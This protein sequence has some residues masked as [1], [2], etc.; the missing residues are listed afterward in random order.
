MTMS[1]AVRS[2]H[3]VAIMVMVMVATIVAM[4]AIP[5]IRL[6]ITIDVFVQKSLSSFSRSLRER[7]REKSL[8]NV[9]SFFKFLKFSREKKRTP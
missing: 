3:L 4:E 7:Y 8:E 9:K 1:V 2:G 5:M 6:L